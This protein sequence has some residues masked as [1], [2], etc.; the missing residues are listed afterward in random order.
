MRL[1]L[2]RPL[3]ERPGPYASV[4]VGALTERDRA[5]QWTSLRD[6]LEQGGGRAGETLEREVLRP[7]QGRAVFAADGEVVLSEPLSDVP[8]PIA[9]VSPLP[10]VTPL[11]LGR[12]ENVPH[13]RVII[14]HAGAELSV[15]GGGSP[16]HTTIE[17][18]DWPLQKTS[19]GGWSQRRYENAVEETWDKN[20]TAVAE[21]IDEQVLRVGAE[22]VLVAGDPQSRPR[23]LDR[24]GAKAAGL[25]VTV[26]HGSRSEHGGFEQDVERALD[27]WLDRRV[28]DLLERHQRQDGPTGLA[29][30]AR[31]LRDG[32]VD[33]LLL[34]GEV[35]ERLWIG[36]D[37]THVSHDA[38]ELRTWG[39]GEP[40]AERADS[41]LIRAAA[42]T[43]AQVCFTDR[44][45]EAT[46][47]LRY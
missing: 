34:P 43:D 3:Y 13:L 19:Q 42:V 40:V 29:G 10:L 16:R 27:D 2:V 36:E 25:V 33:T 4:Y 26:E 6:A 28:S 7:G 15:Y 46:A 39:V 32:R 14:D 21:E 22:L 38:G 24:L 23:L 12:G 41:A 37:G 1:D 35:T 47:V 31:A 20:A 18:D 30:V 8:R 11:L 5:T 17:A 44:V 45:P 9:C